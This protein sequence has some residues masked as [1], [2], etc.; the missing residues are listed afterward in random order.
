MGG[1]DFYLVRDLSLTGLWTS[2]SYFAKE[3]VDIQQ[4]DCYER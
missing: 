4:G 3:E 2:G 1:F